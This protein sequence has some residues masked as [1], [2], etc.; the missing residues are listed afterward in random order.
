MV[1]DDTVKARDINVDTQ[2]GVVTLKGEVKSQSEETKAVEI[3]RT[4]KGVREVVDQLVIV[5]DTAASSGSGI[6]A[7]VSD[8]A[9]TATV[10]SKLLADP[11]TS[12]LRI[13]VD[14]KDRT[15]TLSGA[16]KSAAEKTEAIEIARQTDGVL[17]VN[18]QLTVQRGN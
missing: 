14:T 12:A 6:G 11:D 18:D 15:V 17:G 7:V 16:V 5:P 9:I 10:K 4:T 3:A 8:A 2:N 1:A 13:D